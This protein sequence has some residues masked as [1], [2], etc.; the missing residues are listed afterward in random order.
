MRLHRGA[1]THRSFYTEKCWHKEL[2]HTDA[3]A[4]RSVYTEKLLLR[5]AFTHKGV[6]T[7]KLLHT[8]A[9][10]Q[11]SLYTESFNTQ[12]RLQTETFTQRSLSERAFTHTSPERK[13]ERGDRNEC[14]FH[15]F[16]A[17]FKQN[18]LYRL[19]TLLSFTQRRLYIERLLDTE[20]L[21]TQ[22]F[23]QRNL[24]T[25]CWWGA[26]TQTRLHTEAFTHR[27]F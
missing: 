24:C 15:I 25:N 21:H 17:F 2:L 16:L 19:P 13:L 10:A 3:L 12:A 6:Y 27:S 20:V 22:A 23:T 26:F 8:D 7:Q 18:L 11:R 14:Y 9:V 5:G 4:H 1:F